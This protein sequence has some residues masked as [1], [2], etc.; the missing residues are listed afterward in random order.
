MAL[1]QFLHTCN[2]II[3]ANVSTAIGNDRSFKIKSFT[4]QRII[5]NFNDSMISRL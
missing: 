3:I 4:I 1:G 2:D 5:D